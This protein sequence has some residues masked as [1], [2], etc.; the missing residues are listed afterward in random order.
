MNG[1]PA[2]T[3]YTCPMHRDVRQQ[4]PGK[5]PKC[6]MELLPEGTRFALL[7]HM[8]GKPIHLTLM[9]G[10]MLALMA[11]AMMMLR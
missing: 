6:G 2:P 10:A 11:A 3:I 8:A 4:G 7:R 9:L 5:C 1:N